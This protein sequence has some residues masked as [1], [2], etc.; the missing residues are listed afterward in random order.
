MVSVPPDLF[1]IELG[2]LDVLGRIDRAWGGMHKV[3][4]S[5]VPLR[6]GGS[7]Q[8]SAYKAVRCI[9]VSIGLEIDIEV[10]G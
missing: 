9:T 8:E 10:F 1:L 7:G 2:R 5:N 6:A 3:V 4:S